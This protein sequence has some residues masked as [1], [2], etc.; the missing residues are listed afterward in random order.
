MDMGLNQQ[1]Q[2][3]ISVPH[4]LAM[5]TTVRESGFI[6]LKTDGSL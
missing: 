4:L 3:N 6:I 5:W 1:Q 2:L